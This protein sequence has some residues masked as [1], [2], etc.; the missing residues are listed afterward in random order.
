MEKKDSNKFLNE[1]LKESS[2]SSIYYNI[3]YWLF[4]LLCSVFFLFSKNV[5][6]FSFISGPIIYF[7]VFLIFLYLLIFIFLMFK[8]YILNIKKFSFERE[9]KSLSINKS[10]KNYNI[11]PYLIFS[12]FLFL[13]FLFIY[14]FT[15]FSFLE[16][17]Y[18]I[19]FILLSFIYFFKSIKYTSNN[20]FSRFLSQLEI[21]FKKKYLIDSFLI[22]F[23]IFFIIVFFTTKNEFQLSFLESIFGGF[24]LFS[25]IF[26]TFLNIFKIKLNYKISLLLSLIIVTFYFFLTNGLGIFLTEINY[27]VFFLI[28]VYFLFI[29]F[30][31]FKLYKKKKKFF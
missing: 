16:N 19:I 29:C 5:F 2:F 6:N 15:D 12:V 11:F 17:W 3:V 14:K 1:I 27:R 20:S 13:I 4:F 25:V 26:I 21:T 28:M 23:S 9:I 30:E 22:L 8:E 7:L 31:L 10:D 18:E 24:I